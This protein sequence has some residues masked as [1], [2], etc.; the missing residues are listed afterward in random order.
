MKGPQDGYGWIYEN[1]E[2]SAVDP[3]GAPTVTNLVMTLGRMAEGPVAVEFWNT[4]RGVP[5]ATV[6]GVV[7]DGSLVVAV[8][9]FARDIAF[10]IQRPKGPGTLPRPPRK[11]EE[12]DTI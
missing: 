5:I 4:T 9:P 2:F 1:E 12:G 11:P 8:P 7:A 10:K 6:S 3:Q